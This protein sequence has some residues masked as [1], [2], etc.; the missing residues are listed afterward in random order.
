MG[1]F[2]SD[3]PNPFPKP[4]YAYLRCEEVRELLALVQPG[5]RMY[6]ILNDALITSD[7]RDPDSGHSWGSLY[8][9]PRIWARPAKRKKR[10]K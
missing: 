4:G 6:K 10:G 1:I 8:G 7:Y 3:E 9:D 2:S 5:S